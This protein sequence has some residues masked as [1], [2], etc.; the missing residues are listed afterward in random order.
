MRWEKPKS[1]NMT[2][3]EYIFWSAY[4]FCVC[5]DPDELSKVSVAV[6]VE[7]AKARTVTKQRAALKVVLDVINKIC[8]WPL[9]KGLESS[10]SGMTKGHHAWETFKEFYHSKN[11][12]MFFNSPLEKQKY[13][14]VSKKEFFVTRLY[15][16]VFAS[17]TDFSE[18]TDYLQHSVASIIGGRWMARCGLPKALRG[19]VQRCCYRPRIVEFKANDAVINYL[20]QNGVQTVKYDIDKQGIAC[21]RVKL[22]TGVLM[23]DPLTKVVLHLLNASIRQ[24]G[25]KAHNPAFY[26]PLFSVKRSVE[27]A[28]WYRSYTQPGMT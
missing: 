24:Y 5:S 6:A 2:K 21:C 10:R 14:N 20:R 13:T 23:G 4:H 26:K 25:R 19:I 28:K 16:T 22:V 17:S 8:S 11:A 9:G 27:L 7:P 3:G 15:D 12:S 18:A 1:G